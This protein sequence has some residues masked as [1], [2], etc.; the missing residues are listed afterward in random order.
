MKQIKHFFRKIVKPCGK[1]SF[2]LQLPAHARVLDVGCGNNSSYLTKS[3]RPDCHYTGIDIGDYNQTL[4]NLAD[5]YTISSAEEFPREISRH[6]NEYDAVI[7]SHN[8]EHCDD[9]L[10]VFNAMLSAIKPGGKLY[11]SF[12]NAETVKFPKRQG[13]LNYH[14][15]NTH[16]FNPPDTEEFASQLRQQNFEIIY[17]IEKYQ[18]ILLWTIGLF[19]EP[20]SHLRKKNMLG[21]WE[22]YGFESIIVARKK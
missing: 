20:L 10:E 1:T 2:L 17:S 15:D 19:M 4:P 14:D 22:Y 16:K 5:V 7:S 11:L 3:I 21:T 8:I 9:R 6:Q 12:P 13:T 18:P